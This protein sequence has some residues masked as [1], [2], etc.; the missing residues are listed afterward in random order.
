[1]S[2][3]LALYLY[4]AHPVPIAALTVDDSE[5]T[6]VTAEV[7][8]L[9]DVE[10]APAPA[11]SGGGPI[12]P[13]NNA[14]VN[15]APPDQPATSIS[16]GSAEYGV[17]GMSESVAVTNIDGFI[18]KIVTAVVRPKEGAEMVSLQQFLND[19]QFFILVGFFFIFA[20]GAGLVILLFVLVRR[21]IRKLFSGGR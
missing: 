17:G 15:V 4:M 12:P 8:S 20:V 3:I 6:A 21:E 16:S 1:M 14:S 19:W 5:S 13:R 2:I 11:A 9:G 7:L 10:Q 18:P